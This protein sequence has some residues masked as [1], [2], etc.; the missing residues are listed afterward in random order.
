MDRDLE[1]PRRLA[2]NL[3]RLRKGRGMTQAG[4]AAHSGI[5]RSTIAN[6]ES[7]SGNPSLANLA[8]LAGSLQ[9]SIEELLVRPRGDCELLRAADLPRTERGRGS[10]VLRKLLPDA[11]KG[12]QMERM[13]VLPGGYMRGVPHLR[14]TKEYLTCLSGA[15]RVTVA[16]ED[17]TLGPG[18]VLAFPGD[19]VHGY[20][21]PGRQS[22]AAVSVVVLML[23]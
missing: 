9:V 22:A 2:V 20:H 16:G 21:N 17:F 3:E 1:L 12:L 10:V 19:Q 13:D 6:L 11:L 15:L 7:G 4:L 8:A 18:D 14:G 5:P 23:K